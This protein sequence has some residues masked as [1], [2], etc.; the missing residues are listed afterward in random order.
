MINRTLVI[1]I[2]LLSLA[3]AAIANGPST[4][5]AGVAASHRHSY[6]AAITL[7]TIALGDADL[8][9]RQ[10]ATAFFERGFDYCETARYNNAVAD[11]SQAIR[12]DPAHA[13]SW[14]ERAK[15]YARE[16]LTEQAI[17]DESHAIELK[18]NDPSLYSERAMLDLDRRLWREAEAD[19][20][21]AIGMEPRNANLHYVLGH[22]FRFAGDPVRAVQEETEALD[23]DP[24]LIDAHEERA[25][26]YEDVG[27]YDKALDDFNAKLAHRDDTQVR[28]HIGIAEWYLRRYSDSA[29]SFADLL[30]RI[31]GE[32]NTVLWL[33]LAKTG[34]GDRSFD[35]LAQSARAV[36]FRIWPGP[37]V[38]LYLEKLKLAQLLAIAST[39]TPQALAQQRC[40]VDFYVGEWELH[41]NPATAKALFRQTTVACPPDLVVRRAA[42]FEL[43]RMH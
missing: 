9:A 12:L 20:S 27:K 14:R 23:L 28:F 7:L 13:E 5:V 2:S 31:P 1:G 19:L 29:A 33:A 3:G 16:G 41:A 21:V 15:A 38:A 34:L 11:L 42:A 22:A 30:R 40:D 18:R 36:N 35:E 4:F 43:A 6:D 39:G 37:I 32:S 26:A 24:S 8:P 10:K 25:A 17:A